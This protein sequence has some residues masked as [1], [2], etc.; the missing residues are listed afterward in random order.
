[1]T[2]QSVYFFA[3]HATD[4][5]FHAYGRIKRDDSGS[6]DVT[7]CGLTLYDDDG[8][9]R[10]AAYLPEK[11]AVKFARPCAKCFEKEQR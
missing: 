9:I 1:M 5:V 4:P 3:L 11:H 7:I 8:A 6:S 10:Y 2:G